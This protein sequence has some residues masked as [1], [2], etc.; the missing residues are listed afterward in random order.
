MSV[1]VANRKRR[2]QFSLGRRDCERGKWRHRTNG[3]LM[4]LQGLPA[5]V[6][7]MHF[8]Y[9]GF[10]ECHTIGTDGLCRVFGIAAG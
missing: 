1:P 9:V 2:T 10:F 3:V 5:S 8:D 7:R 4:R 6:L